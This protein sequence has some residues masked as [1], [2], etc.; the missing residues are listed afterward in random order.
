MRQVVRGGSWN[1][2][3]NNL[4][5]CNRNNN[6]ANNRNSNIGFRLFNAQSGQDRCAMKSLRECTASPESSPD[7]LLSNDLLEVSSYRSNT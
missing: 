1:N 4:R 2:N 3:P 5:V 7:T 6:N